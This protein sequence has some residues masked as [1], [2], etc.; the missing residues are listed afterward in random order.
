M[1]HVIAVGAA[2]EHETVA[3]DLYEFRV[4][5]FGQDFARFLGGQSGSVKHGAFDKLTLFN[6]LIRLLDA[7]SLRSFL[8][9]WM[10]GLSLVAR[11]RNCLTCFL[12][13]AI[14]CS[15]PIYDACSRVA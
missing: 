8:P 7:F 12:V 4:Q 1:L 2:I 9:T 15:I 10:S 14:T 3:D 5:F 6:G 13:N 11:P